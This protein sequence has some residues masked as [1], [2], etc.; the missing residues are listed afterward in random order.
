M[1]IRRWGILLLLGAIGARAETGYDA[2]LRYTF[3][4]DQNVR[5]TYAHLP[6][7]IATLDATTVMTT[8]A[9]EA[10]RGVRGMLGRTLRVG[11]GVAQGRL[12]SA[13]RTARDTTC[14]ARAFVAGYI[15]RRR[16][17]VKDYGRQWAFHSFSSGGE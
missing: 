1:S 4:D 10:G 13:G 16:L 8:A 11:N 6:A 14:S 5:Q 3:I 17:F 15:A 7:A 9:Q 2:W 12:H